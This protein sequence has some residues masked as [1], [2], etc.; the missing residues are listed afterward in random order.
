MSFKTSVL[1]WVVAAVTLTGCGSAP[2]KPGDPV[3]SASGSSGADALTL[4]TGDL[5]LAALDGDETTLADCTDGSDNGSD[6]LADCDDEDCLA[7]CTDSDGDGYCEVGA[8]TDASGACDNTEINAATQDCAEGDATVFPGS[9]DESTTPT[10]AF[11]T[12]TL[13]N[14]CDGLPDLVDPD[15][16]LADVDNDVDGYCENGFRDNNTD[17]ICAEGGGGEI[18]CDDNITDGSSSVPNGTAETTY[19]LCNDGYDNDCANG[20]GDYGA[21]ASCALFDGTEDNFADCTDGVDNDGDGDPDGAD[22]GCTAYYDNDGDTYCED[23]TNCAGGA[24]PGDCDDDPVVGDNSVPGGTAETTFALCS[25]GYDNDCAG[26]AD[27]LDTNC[28]SW[29]DG[30]SDGFCADGTNCIDGSTPGDCADGDGQVY[31]G[32]TDEETNVNF[33]ICS[34]L[35]DND[36]SEGTDATD[37][38]CAAFTGAENT[39]ATC[40]DGLD[41]DGDGDPDGADSECSPFYD[42]DGDTYCEDPTNCAGG[43][44]PGDCDDDPVVGANSVPG[45]ASEASF[46]L[47][48]DGYD[49]D[50]GNGGADAADGSCSPWVDDDGDGFCED[51]SNCVTGLPGDCDDDPVVGSNSVPGGTSEATFALCSDG[52]DND[53]AGGADVAD[54][55]CGPWVDDDGDGYCEDGSSCVTGLPG[56]CDDDPVVG[57]NS[58]PNGL[59]E[60]TYG[61]CSDGYDNDCV[62]GTDATDSNCTPWLDNDGDGFCE[63]ATNCVTG[64]PGDCMDVG[65]GADQAYPGNTDEES[66]AGAANCTDGLDNDCAEG[67][68]ALD[69]DCAPYVTEDSAVNCSDGVDNDGDGDPDGADSGCLP[70]YDNDGDGY[71]DDLVSCADGTSPGDCLDSNLSVN[72]GATENTAVDCADLLDNDCFEGADAASSSCDPFEDNDGDG[73]CESAS[74]ITGVPG[75]CNDTSTNSERAYPGNTQEGTTANLTNC[76]DGLDNDCIQGPDSNDP[77]CTPFGGVEDNYALCTDGFDNDGDSLIDYPNDPECDLYTGNE[78]TFT[79]CNDPVDNDGDGDI[80]VADSDCAPWVDNDGDG[81]CESAQC[82]DGSLPADCND[83]VVEA[84]PNNTEDS[85]ALCSDGGI[86]NDC[87]GFSDSADSDCF[88]W[89]DNDGDG[90]CENG[91]N[92]VDGSAAGDCNDSEAGESPGL[93][94]TTLAVCGDGLNNDCDANTD[95]GDSGCFPWVDNDGDGNCENGST[96]VDGSA[97]GDCNDGEAG[98]DPDNSENTLVLC[99][100]TLDNDCSGFTDGGD[101]ACAPWNDDDGDGYCEASNGCIGGLPTDDCDDSTGTRSPGN[102]EDTFPLCDDNIDNDCNFNGDEAD[103]AC[104]PWADNDFDGYCED[105]TSC[106]NGLLTGDCDDAVAG[107]SP[108]L[109]ENTFALCNDALDNDCD[110]NTGAS[111]SDC[112][113]WVDDDGDGQCESS[114]CVD[115]S[116]GGTPDCDDTDA[117]E[118]VR[119]AEDT[120]D[121]NDMKD[122]DCDTNIDLADSDCGGIEDLDNDGYCPNGRDINND[123]VC[124]TAAETAAQADC[125]EGNSGRYP[126]NTEVVADNIDQDCDFGDD[127]YLD[128]DNDDFGIGTVVQASTIDCATEANVSRF[129]NDCDDNEVTTYP[130]AP[131]SAGDGVDQDCNNTDMCYR[132]DDNDNFGQTTLLDGL[133]L[134]CISD[135]GRAPVNTDCDDGAPNNFPGNVEVCDGV[136]NNCAAGADEPGPQVS[137]SSWYLDSDGDNHG[138]AANLV[139][140]CDGAPIGYVA[141]SD[142]C[143]DADGINYPGNTEICDGQDN[144]CNGLDDAGNPGTNNWETDNDGD[145]QRECEADCDDANPNRFNGNLETPANNLD[146]D[147]D[148]RELCYVDTDLDTFGNSGGAT[149]LSSTGAPAWSC[150][151]SGLSSANDDCNDADPNINVA[152]PEGIADNVD[153]N[154]DGIELCYQDADNDTHGIESGLTVN[155]PNL[156]CTDS[157]ES[158]IADDCDDTEPT[159]YTGAPE[160]LFDGIDQDCNGVDAVE[161]FTDSDGDQVGVNVPFIGAGIDGDCLD[162]GES[163]SS[164]DC[165]DGDPS[166]HPGFVLANV[167]TI[168]AGTEICGDGVDSDCDGQNGPNWDDDGDGLTYNEETPLGLDDCDPDVDGDTLVDGVEVAN[169]SDPT[170]PDTDGDSVTDD[171]EYTTG[172][173]PSPRFTDSDSDPDYNDTDDDNDGIPTIL[174]EPNGNTDGDGQPDFRDDDDDDDGIPTIEEGDASQN[175][176]GDALPN[177]RDEDDDDDSI[178]TIIEEQFNNG[179]GIDFDSDGLFGYLDADSDDDGVSDGIEWFAASRCPSQPPTGG[180]CNFDGAGGPDIQDTDDDNDT[181]L[182]LVE[183]DETV[184]T[185]GDGT[186]DY[187]DLDSDAD[188]I[189]DEVEAASGCM[190]PKSTD[191]DSDTVE[192]GVEFGF[193]PGADNTDAINTSPYFDDLIDPCDPDDD[194]DTILTLEEVGRNTDAP[195]SLPADLQAAEA[196]LGQAIGD[197]IPDYLDRDDDGDGVP[198]W[199]EDLNAD[200]SALNDDTD[201]DGTPDALDFDDD[202][203]NIESFFEEFFIT[204]RLYEDSDFDDVRDDIEWGC[205]VGT[206]VGGRTK[207]QPRNTD[208]EA[209]AGAGAYSCVRNAQNPSASALWLI[210][211]GNADSDLDVLDPDDDNDGLYTG[212]IPVGGI[213]SEFG[214]S[215]DDDG[216]GIPSYRDLDAD[217]DSFIDLDGDGN[218]DTSQRPDAC[219]S[220]EDWDNDTIPNWIDR[221]DFDGETGDPDGD[222]LVTAVELE[223]GTNPGNPDSDGD[224]VLDC[225]EALPA[226]FVNPVTL[227]TVICPDVAGDQDID[228]D[229]W[230]AQGWT[231]PDTDFDGIIDVLD[232]DDDGDGIPSSVEVYQGINADGTLGVNFWCPNSPVE[233]RPSL[234]FRD[235]QTDPNL[236]PIL[237]HVYECPVF[238]PL[239]PDNTAEF[240]TIN[241]DAI[242]RDGD[243]ITNRLDSDDDGDGVPTRLEDPNGNGEYFDLGESYDDPNDDDTDGDGIL[244][245]L[246]V[247]DFDGPVADPDN[248]GLTNEE[249]QII[250]DALQLSEQDCELIQTD[251]DVD[252]DGIADIYEVGDPN[253]PTDT[254]GD[255]IAD[256]FDDDDDNDCIPSSEEGVGDYDEDGIPAYQDDDSDGDGISDNEEWF[257]TPTEEC[258]PF[259]DTFPE[260]LDADCD[261]TK[262]VADFFNDDGP[263]ALGG[264][265]VVVPPVKCGCDSNSSGTPMWILAALGVL[266]LRRRRAA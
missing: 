99:D 116:P 54:S 173:N 65:A 9:P 75:D 249:E 117:D 2:D 11:C 10:A 90:Y 35:K 256:I 60:T 52:Y 8:D 238:D 108:G 5:D 109:P 231:A 262:D 156:I 180:P 64:S 14:D 193:G 98:E 258:P 84:A 164:A 102:T 3:D 72:P 63:D 123:G 172:A 236:D 73:Y 130:G 105:P 67:P 70:F 140:T 187:L 146:N 176:D 204:D 237:E 175:T 36:C 195:A 155:S 114:S 169:G 132:D 125:E 38:D 190:N 245:Y 251:A 263:C 62:G 206:C 12:D 203:D 106:I 210:S 95:S 264:D 32:N 93:N 39:F 200:Q 160:I 183:G 115:G 4:P 166:V 138:D 232:E 257:G 118:F 89:V 170:N 27:A 233:E 100:D 139:S 127:C 97:P 229:T 24:T 244:E 182:T 217:D 243:G 234:E 76:T 181:I 33:T 197:D 61:R 246:D 186:P 162:A 147:C 83:G 226:G 47:C 250:C 178:L 48:S 141:S 71:C 129:N 77:D 78:D 91:S 126:G 230:M 142:D 209:N 239:D 111:D 216:D 205:P 261:G 191:T 113:P 149:Q 37:P 68:D 119:A 242:D 218:I 121:C 110:G 167:I 19:A 135:L 213:L 50:C 254:D 49:N 80:G 223:L 56:D 66:T 212:F 196:T 28:S 92:C 87:D 20:G 58:V 184:D 86:D 79:L 74:C 34:D 194:G 150:T 224:G 13:D 137:Y 7:F 253:N 235:V 40:T 45:G 152:A 163:Y 21:D 148:N 128:N 208:A 228:L 31:P 153:Q 42:D 82:I 159:I 259:D 26:G 154:C 168:A 136:D 189:D 260:A 120:A 161:C 185:D 51:G 219:E 188:T 59:T 198:T 133:S 248:D 41:N 171:R 202:N 222:N 103:T 46:A 134:S 1:I 88:P 252:N 201:G 240:V 177:Y 69:L 220:S 174:E 22:A 25:D 225:Q 96:C 221:N 17:G 6:G 57:D 131:E 151:A 85:F 101:N 107:E 124:T 157:G 158:G 179:R 104:E 30:D 15:C 81:Y 55:N 43:A 266:G 165:N 255:G 211:E 265:G 227:A 122:N 143:D 145:G 18:D 23:G 192:D 247:N 215:V 16:Q 44:T 199:F 29:T 214:N 112:A 207:L 144:D 241:P 53:C 94:E